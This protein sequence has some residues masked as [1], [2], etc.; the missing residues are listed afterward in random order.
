MTGNEFLAA[1]LATVAYREGFSEG[2]NGLL[3]IAFCLRYRVQAGWFGGKW[4]DVL[5]HHAEVSW[6]D[7]AKEPF[8]F[9]VPDVTKY[10]FQLFLQEVLGIISGSRQDSVLVA[11][12]SIRNYI[13]VGLPPRPPL[14]YGRLDQIA[15]PWFEQNICGHQNEHPLVA[16]VGSL[17]FFA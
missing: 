16:Q 6:R 9:F 4:A 8:T 5:D 10:S 1:N 2:L 7:P 11:Q 15:N 14:Y 12:D 13:T 17:S 3:G